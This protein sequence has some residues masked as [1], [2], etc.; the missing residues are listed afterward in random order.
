MKVKALSSVHCMK[1]QQAKLKLEGLPIEWHDLE[2]RD[3][4]VL[5]WIQ[6]YDLDKTP[7]FLIFDDDEKYIRLT[8]NVL[9]VRDLL[10]NAK[11]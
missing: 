6:L 7:T 11:D 3:P 9:E 4:E 5:E 8:T 10:R 2:F 1:C